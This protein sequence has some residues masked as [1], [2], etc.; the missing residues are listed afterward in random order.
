[1]SDTCRKPPGQDGPLG[2]VWKVGRRQEMPA[3]WP[4]RWRGGGDSQKMGSPVRQDL[5]RGQRVRADGQPREPNGG[6][7]HVTTWQG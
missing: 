5:R 2:W 6:R 7:D 4:E 3:L 1:M